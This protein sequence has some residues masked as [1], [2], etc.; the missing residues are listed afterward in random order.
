MIFGFRV[1]PDDAN[2]LGEWTKKMWET[3]LAYQEQNPSEHITNMFGETQNTVVSPIGEN[4]WSIKLRFIWDKPSIAPLILSKNI[5]AVEEGINTSL[6]IDEDEYETLLE[7][8]WTFATARLYEY[9][10]SPSSIATFTSFRPLDSKDW[11]SLTNF[12]NF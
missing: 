11:I 8:G 2:T 3:I 7:H 1:A 12:D 10:F 6:S 5:E 4:D 9:S